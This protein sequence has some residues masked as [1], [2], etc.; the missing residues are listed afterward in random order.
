VKR[1][2]TP[3]NSGATGIVNKELKKSG[4][5][6]RKALNRFSTKIAVHGTL[7]IIRKVLQS[8]SRRL[9]WGGAPFVKE[10]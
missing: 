3:A 5:N 8:E 4:N 9:N 6:S 10:K 2:G 1:F 7:H